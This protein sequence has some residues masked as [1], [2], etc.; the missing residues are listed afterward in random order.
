[1]LY[2]S[3]A[4]PAQAEEL[5]GKSDVNGEELIVGEVLYGVRHAALAEQAGDLA[6]Q[7]GDPHVARAGQPRAVGRLHEA[8]W[9]PQIRPRLV[10]HHQQ[11]RLH[12]REHMHL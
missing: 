1:M 12:A 10:H 9:H 2:T 6:V 8:T 11:M 5:T 7:G 4:L 3:A